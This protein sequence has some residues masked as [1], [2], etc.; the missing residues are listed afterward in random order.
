M[1]CISHTCT[2]FTIR[3]STHCVS[4]IGC[5]EQRFNTRTV[6]KWK[7]SQA[8]S[9][10]YIL[11]AH[12]F[13]LCRRMFTL[14][15][16]I[17]PPAELRHALVATMRRSARPMVSNCLKLPC[18]DVVAAVAQPCIAAHREPSALGSRCM[19]YLQHRLRGEVVVEQLHPCVGWTRQAIVHADFDG[20]RAYLRMVCHQ[21]FSDRIQR[22][23]R[24]LSHTH[25]FLSETERYLV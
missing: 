19:S 3:V 5:T 4:E 22:A 11:D 14:A 25:F 7:S 20:S 15:S 6:T 23:F 16:D 21:L 9:L 8:F 24:D 1:D 10:L 12:H 18:T 17:G 2:F 13:L